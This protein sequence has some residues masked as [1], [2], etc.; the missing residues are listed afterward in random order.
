VGR[1]ILGTTTKPLETR[2]EVLI[3][4]RYFSVKGEG[5]WLE[6]GERLNQVGKAAGEVLALAA[7][8]PDTVGL[9][10][11]HTVAVD[12]LF[13]YPAFVMERARQ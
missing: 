13:V 12:L 11:H 3:E 4:D 2:H 8:Q 5:L 10:S 9:A 7:N 1:L 6:A